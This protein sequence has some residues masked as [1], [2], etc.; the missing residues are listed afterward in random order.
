MTTLDLLCKA[1]GWQGGTI[2]NAIEHFATMDKT[3]QDNIFN[4]YIM[5]N[6]YDINDLENVKKLSKIRISHLIIK[7]I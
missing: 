5:P 2:H 3:A 1:Y 4:L 6:L 7:G